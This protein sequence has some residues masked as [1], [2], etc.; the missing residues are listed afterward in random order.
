M[1]PSLTKCGYLQLSNLR[2]Y[3]ARQLHRLCVLLREKDAQQALQDTA[4]QLLIR[5]AVSAVQLVILFPVAAVE[6]RVC[7]AGMC[8]D[9]SC[10]VSCYF[11]GG[12]CV[13]SIGFGAPLYRS[14]L[15]TST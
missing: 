11:G 3:P 5:Q 14:S 8:V 7:E 4:V 1:L 13:Y 2:A 6:Q 10:F 15:S 12:E 9:L